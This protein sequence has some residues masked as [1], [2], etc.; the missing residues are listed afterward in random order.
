MRKKIDIWHPHWS[1]ISYCW[2][3]FKE[4]RPI[5][6]RCYTIYALSAIFL[7]KWNTYLNNNKRDSSISKGIHFRKKKNI[8]IRRIANCRNVN[9]KEKKQ[10]CHFTKFNYLVWVSYCNYFM[11]LV[12]RM[13]FFI[14]EKISRVKLI[15]DFPAKTYY[16]FN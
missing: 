13:W 10:S 1:G 16:N 4:N 3:T 11:A 14:E 8:Y 9:S 15:Y 7:N 12:N 6:S 2:T 5:K